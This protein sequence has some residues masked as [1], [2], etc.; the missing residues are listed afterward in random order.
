MS[1][2][3]KKVLIVGAATS[4]GQTV[5]EGFLVSGASVLATVHHQ[6]PQSLSKQ[7]ITVAEANLL[8]PASLEQFCGAIVPNFG[9]IDVAIFLSGVL[10]GRSLVDYDDE[11]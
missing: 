1:L 10:P 6:K 11:L 7:G 4:I 2:R 8:D 5:V 9:Q 3:G